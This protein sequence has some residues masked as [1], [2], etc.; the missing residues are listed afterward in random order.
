MKGLERPK[1]YDIHKLILLIYHWVIVPQYAITWQIY[2]SW[3][4]WIIEAK[5]SCSQN[6]SE[7]LANMIEGGNKVEKSSPAWLATVA[8]IALNY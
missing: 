5:M 2:E 8:L 3:Y 6:W 4:F 1:T 7:I